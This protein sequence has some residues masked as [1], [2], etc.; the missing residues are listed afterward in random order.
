LSQGVTIIK[1][2][3]LQ[4]LQRSLRWHRFCLVMRR[5]QSWM[6]RMN[7]R[8]GFTFTELLVV[9]ALIGALSAMAVPRYRDFKA[10][11]SVAA[12]QSDLGNLKIAQE[13]YWSEHQVY[14]TDTTHLELRITNLVAISIS[15]KDVVGGYT[16]VAMHANVP[17]QQ[18]QTAMGA[19]AAPREQGAIFCGLTSGGNNAIPS[20]P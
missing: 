14:A 16:A 13:S 19:E 7:R 8:R 15:S 2:L 10:R 9:M 17:G 11:A 3:Q 6:M 5:N 1:Y 4:Q 12:M 18:C 20:A